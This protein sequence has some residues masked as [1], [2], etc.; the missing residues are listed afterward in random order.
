[1]E[2]IK[3]VTY[4]TSALKAPRIQASFARL[5]DTGRAQGWTFE[6]YLA[7][8][9]EAE[10]TAREA[11][12]AEI[13]RKRAHF[14]S[15]KT[16]E[17]FTFDHQPHLRSDVQ[18][19]SRSTWIHNAENMILLGP[20]GTGK[21]HISIG[22]GIAATR[23]G[24]P[25]LFDTAA[26]WIQSLTAAHNKGDLTKELRRIRRYKLIIIDELGY[27][28]IEPEAANLFFQLIS[29]RYEQSSIL[30]TSNL[31]F[32]SWSTIFHDET[33]ATAIIDRLVH[34]AQVLTTKGTSYRI[35][36]RQEQGTVN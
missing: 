5:A 19:A 32:G 7:A 18:A 25:V 21:T 9:L 10:V 28:P 16:I 17:D 27:L 22:L 14:P 11:S 2:A 36:H 3:D 15:M 26:G 33:I 8:V 20:P 6:E 35:R 30:I 12:G 24:I 13:R 29:D 1:M 4:Y 31:A 23:A 34:H